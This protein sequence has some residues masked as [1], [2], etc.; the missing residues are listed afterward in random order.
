M[1]Y[2]DI[3]TKN[4][5]DRL[6]HM[7]LLKKI[8]IKYGLVGGM[9]KSKALLITTLTEVKCQPRDRYITPLLTLY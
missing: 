8:G 1:K 5:A 9:Q 3:C 7:C 6:Y 2:L 4:F